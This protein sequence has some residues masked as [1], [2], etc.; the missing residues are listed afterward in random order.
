MN[1]DGQGF[2]GK[3]RGTVSD[4]KDPEERGRIRAKVLDV[5]GDGDSG[6]ALPCAPAGGITQTGF[7]A[8]PP[9]GA[10][11]WMEFEHGDPEYPVWSGC[12]W[13]VKK[14]APAALQP[15]PAEQVTIVTKGGNKITLSDKQGSEGITLETSKG[16]KLAIT[17]D[18]IEIV[19]DKGASIKLS[20]K[21]VS[22]ND[23]ALE[24][25]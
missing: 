2:W 19:N 16:A 8:V 11:V 17:A 23:G 10:T 24:V 1:G 18:G 3:Y 7:F 13:A 15:S 22:V 12:F 6:W 14:D 5:F 21:T 20:G 4:N 9:T 25:T